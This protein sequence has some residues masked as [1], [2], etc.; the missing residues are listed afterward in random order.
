M[1]KKL[2]KLDGEKIIGSK[3]NPFV[4]ED[5]WLEIG[6]TNNRQW[7]L[8]NNKY[9]YIDNELVEKTSNELGNE[10]FIILKNQKLAEVDTEARKLI[11]ENIGDLEKQAKYLAKFSELTNKRVDGI[12]LTD[13]E[14]T[15]RQSLMNMHKLFKKIADDEVDRMRSEINNFTDKKKEMLSNYV[16]QFDTTIPE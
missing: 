10:K 1:Y 5:G 9:K 7:Y 12:E 15:Q 11:Y 16:I 8:D 6:E 2:I 13:E 3:T 14:E 4:K